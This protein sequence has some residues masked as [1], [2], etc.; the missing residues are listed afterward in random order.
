[1]ISPLCNDTRSAIPNCHK[2]SLTAGHLTQEVT[3]H[4]LALKATAAS[5][6]SAC[7]LVPIEDDNATSKGADPP[8]PQTWWTLLQGMRQIALYPAGFP[9]FVSATDTALRKQHGIPRA[10]AVYYDPPYPNTTLKAAVAEETEL[11][12]TDTESPMIMRFRCRLAGVRAVAAADTQASHCFISTKFVRDNGIVTTPAHRMVELADGT[13]AQLHAECNIKMF[14]PAQNR[15]TYHTSLHCLVVDLGDDHDIIL[16]QTW[17]NA[18]SVDVSY[19]RRIIVAGRHR[20]V[21]D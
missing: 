8:P 13:H 10:F 20:L 4:Y 7:F 19:G 14:M 2:L 21:I 9:L 6:T 17:L 16:G 5:N 18:E 1:V 11:P 12:G 15:A 3:S